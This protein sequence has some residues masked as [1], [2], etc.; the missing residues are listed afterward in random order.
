MTAKPN[1]SKKSASSGINRVPLVV[2]EKPIAWP[3]PEARS[4]A[5]LRRAPKDS[6]VNQR[7]TAEKGEVDTLL[8]AGFG[9]QQIH[10]GQCRFQRH[11][12]W[13]GPETSFPGITVGTAKIALLGDRQGQRPDRHA[14]RRRVVDARRGGSEAQVIEDSAQ[15]LAIER[16][17]QPGERALV[18]IEQAAPIDDEGV[19]PVPGPKQ[20]HVGRARA[21]R[22]RGGG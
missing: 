17:T 14:D 12:L 22:G 6:A 13:R 2:I 4:R 19:A 1:S 5:Y 7:L 20:M 11:V 18:E 15:V 3:R 16:G 10:G 9:Q 21:G 8:R